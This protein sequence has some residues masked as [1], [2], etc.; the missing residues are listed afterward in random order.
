MLIPIILDDVVDVDKRRVRVGR[1][2][3]AQVKGFIRL[4]RIREDLRLVSSVTS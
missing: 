1:G 2:A 4:V 3:R